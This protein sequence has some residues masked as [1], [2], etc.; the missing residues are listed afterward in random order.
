MSKKER[1]GNSSSLLLFFGGGLVL[2]VTD[3]WAST[4]FTQTLWSVLS[5]FRLGALNRSGFCTFVSQIVPYI[6][7]TKVSFL[8]STVHAETAGA[9]HELEG[10]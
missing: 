10:E 6:H 5:A 8:T 2:I 7:P 3:G 4:E 1:R 9:R